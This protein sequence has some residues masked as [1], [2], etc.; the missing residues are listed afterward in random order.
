M[1]SPSRR[2]APRSIAGG[3]VGNVL[4][5]YDFAVF[6]YFAP[7]IG[8]QFF[9]AGNHGAGLLG[10]FAIFAGA[11]FMRPIGG[12]LL[13]GLG[14]RLGRRYALQLSVLLMAVPTTAMALLPTYQQVG[15][16]A[17]ALLLVCRLVQGLSVGGELVGSMSFITESAPPDRR[18]L[19]GSFVMC[20]ATVGV[21]IGSAA[22]ALLDARLDAAQ[23]ASWGW[24]LPFAA[25]LLLGLFGLWMRHGLDESPDYQQLARDGELSPRP[26]REVLRTMP[27]AMCM[28]GCLVMLSAGGFYILFVW[29]PTFLARFVDPP[30]PGAL[31][32]NTISMGVL[33]ALTPVAGWLSDLYGRRAILTGSVVGLAVL[34]VP[35]FQLASTGSPGAALVAQIVFAVQMA[36]VTAP[37]PAT[38][39]ELFPTRVRQTGVSVGYNF[40][41][42]MF[43]GTAPLM[44]TLLFTRTASAVA[45]A[46]YLSCLAVVSAL[47]SRSVH[48]FAPAGPAAARP[49]LASLT[50]ARFLRGRP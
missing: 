29:W 44:A 22:A 6:G 1:A 32:L 13:G 43:G 21:M 39:M 45:P 50:L 19:F 36:G 7:V 11:Y 9:P 48:D 33:A 30:V 31:T 5:W 27:G 20:S 42:A 8:E 16:L 38:M 24:R 41:V 34:A 37:L 26:L 49:R 47:A 3:V 23:L 46:C 25:G 10:A 17:P 18:G 12:A 2:S 4:E 14:D 15:W 28:I 35:L 40:A